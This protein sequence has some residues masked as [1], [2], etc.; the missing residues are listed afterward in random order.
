MKV[1][2]SNVNF[3]SSSGPN[4][5]GGRL[6]QELAL[7][8][9]KIVDKDDDYDI[10]LCFIEPASVPAQKARFI[11]RLDGIWFKPAQFKTHNVN[12]KSAYNKCDHVIWQSNFDKNMTEKWWGKRIGSVIPN[13]IEIKS[14][15]HNDPT[16][17]RIRASYDKVFVS[18]S[19]WHRQK[20]LKENIELFLLLKKR[21]KNACL[22]VMGNPD[23]VVSHPDVI[24]VGHIPHDICL[25]IYS[26]AD[27]MIHLAW[28]DHCPNVVVEAI[29]QKCSVICTDSGGTHEIVKDNGIIINETSPYKFEL[30]DYD[31]PYEI[32]LQ[33]IDLPDLNIEND[34]LNIKVAADAY[35]KVF[36]G[37]K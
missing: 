22:I 3:S 12:I 17:K 28:L 25:Q 35:E 11:H 18:S 13:G 31:K 9:Y 14:I 34:Y 4:S 7:R 16:L 26:I 33:E 30:T 2:F 19:S 5:F 1:H 27:W 20:R 32:K 6:A 10:F 37:E 8:N 15:V 24:Y 29:S 21:Y 36:K 23:H